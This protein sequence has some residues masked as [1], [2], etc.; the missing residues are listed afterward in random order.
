[1]KF[2]RKLINTYRKSEV[3]HQ[4]RLD[5]ARPVMFIRFADVDV[6]RLPWDFFGFSD[7]EVETWGEWQELADAVLGTDR[8]RIDQIFGE[9]LAKD[10]ASRGQQ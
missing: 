2:E 6:Y 4:N 9:I 3:C 7:E 1:M 5:R 8:P 10:M